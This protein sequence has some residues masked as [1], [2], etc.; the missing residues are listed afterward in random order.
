MKMLPVTPLILI[1]T[2]AFSLAGCAD[3]GRETA[4][5]QPPAEESTASQSETEQP[6][7]EQSSAGEPTSL[8]SDEPDTPPKSEDA[9]ALEP[10]ELGGID[11]LHVFGGKIYLAGQPSPEDLQL[12]K[13]KGIKTIVNLRTDREIDWDEPAQ[14]KK[15]GLEYCPLTVDG[16]EGFTD[17]VFDEARKLFQD[18]SKH[19]ILVH[20][21]TANRVGT[22]WLAHRVLDDG[23]S[24]D[25]ALAE[26]KTVG[27]RQ[28]EC[29]AKA[30]EYIEREKEK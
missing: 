17:E 7:A 8:T 3:A 22:L 5:A 25:A 14:T 29:E 10:A 28:A 30:K 16:A 11:N 13:E 12:A 15:A 2:I 26:A 1:F 23:L 18:A 9:G 24:Y 27:L 6:A 19:P 21:G 20:C 4:T